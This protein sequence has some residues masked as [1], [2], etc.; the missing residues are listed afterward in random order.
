MWEPQVLSLGWEDP[1]KKGMATHSSIFAWR[2]LWTEEPG[3]L[4]SMGLQRIRQDWATH[5]HIHSLGEDSPYE[6]NY[7]IHHLT[8][9]SFVCVWEHLGSILLANFNYITVLSII[10]IMLHIRP[11][12]LIHLVID[13][14]YDG[15][16]GCTLGRNTCNSRIHQAFWVRTSPKLL[17]IVKCYPGLPRGC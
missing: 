7:H 4:Q 5:T 10:V 16:F 14:L 2:I 3:R 13:S 9:L 12:D 1:L 11:S 17:K 8:N 6:V 15:F